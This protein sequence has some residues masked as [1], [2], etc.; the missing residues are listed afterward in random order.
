MGKAIERRKI[1]GIVRGE[2]EGKGRTRALGE[3][4]VGSEMAKTERG[5]DGRARREE[6]VTIRDFG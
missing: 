4:L 5:D 1:C 3:E 2:S 6:V